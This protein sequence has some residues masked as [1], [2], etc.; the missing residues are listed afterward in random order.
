MKIHVGE[1]RRI[2]REVLGPRDGASTVSCDGCGGVG[3]LISPRETCES[4]GGTG[5]RPVAARPSI[6][7]GTVPHTK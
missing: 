5:R 7:R 6:G 1:I 4:C 2:V 3:E